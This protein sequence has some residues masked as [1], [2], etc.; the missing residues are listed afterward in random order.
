M[1]ALDYVK[2]KLPARHRVWEATICYLRVH[3]LMKDGKALNGM[4]CKILTTQHIKNPGGE[5]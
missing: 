4:K 5:T 1:S 2:N 3:P